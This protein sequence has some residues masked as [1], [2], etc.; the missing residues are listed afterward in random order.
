MLV[1]LGPSGNY[2]MQFMLNS[3]LWSG[4]QAQHG[5]ALDFEA[6]LDT[7]EV[8]WPV[9]VGA[10]RSVLRPEGQFPTAR[11]TSFRH[12]KRG[13]RISGRSQFEPAAVSF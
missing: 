10:L 4:G 6:A 5:V 12:V 3:L 9:L 8:L 2:H 1:V 13:P 7:P 11:P